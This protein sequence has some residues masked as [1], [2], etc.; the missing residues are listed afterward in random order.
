MPKSNDSLFIKKEVKWLMIAFCYDF[1]SKLLQRLLQNADIWSYRTELIGNGR[2]LI[3]SCWIHL[4]VTAM[5]FW[6]IKKIRLLQANY[7]AAVLNN[8]KNEYSITSASGLSTAQS[9]GS[10]SETESSKSKTETRKKASREFSAHL[11]SLSKIFGSV[12]SASK[13][14]TSNSTDSITEK[15]CA[16]FANNVLLGLF[17]QYLISEFSSELL[18][19]LIELTQFQN[20]VLK[21]APK[22]QNLNPNPN[23]NMDDNAVNVELQEVGVKHEDMKERDSTT[24]DRKQSETRYHY[25]NQDQNQNQDRNGNTRE[26]ELSSLQLAILNNEDIPDSYIVHNAALFKQ[27][28]LELEIEELDSESGIAKF[29]LSAYLLYQ[30]YITDKS[31]FQINISYVRKME[32]ENLLSDP[33]RWMTHYNINRFDLFHLYTECIEELYVLLPQVYYRFIE[34][35]EYMKYQ[36]VNPV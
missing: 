35:E 21:W 12:A 23:L 16:L 17:M 36:T 29:K 10:S 20:S 22:Y 26:L 1:F 19:A 9:S 6:Q 32:L 24:E 33:Q 27:K 15:L 25:Q 2:D 11:S 7:N 14:S 5:I 13:S 4:T 34:S 31:E 3:G 18:L 28:C 30:K 8:D